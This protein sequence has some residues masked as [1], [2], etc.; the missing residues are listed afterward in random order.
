MATDVIFFLKDMPR[1]S[2]LDMPWRSPVKLIGVEPP[3]GV[4]GG[5][6]PRCSSAYSALW[7][8]LRGPDGRA[9][10]GFLNRYAR[11]V[12]VGRVAFVGFSAAHGFLNPLA[13]NDADRSMVD[14]Y[15]LM[16]ASFGGG[17]TGYEK[18][19]ADAAA[20]Q[21]M[22]ATVTSNTGGD[23][24]WRAVWEALAPYNAV[25]QISPRNM[26]AP[27]GGAWRMGAAAYYLRYVNPSNQQ[28]SLRHWEMGPYTPVMVGDYLLPWW[29]SLGAL[30]LGGLMLAAAGVYVAWETMRT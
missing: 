16:D 7:Q 24:S 2:I 4:C 13:N 23:E 6:D 25:S 14:A 19:L 10:P 3:R 1:Q 22:L 11:G 8:Q 9:M 27:D 30:E 21:R 17:K 12:D 20:G 18:F 15:V 29:N 28:S 5:S 26:P